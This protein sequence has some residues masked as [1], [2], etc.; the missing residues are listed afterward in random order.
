MISTNKGGLSE[1]GYN[2]VL[3]ARKKHAQARFKQPVEIIK[4]NYL[5][6]WV[7]FKKQLRFYNFINPMKYVAW[8]ITGPAAIVG[9]VL[10]SWGDVVNARRH[11]L[12]TR[13]AAVENLGYLVSLE[14]R[15]NPSYKKAVEAAVEQKGSK[16]KFK[17]YK[18]MYV[19][20]GGRIIFTAI[21]R[22]NAADVS[23]FFSKV[24]SPYLPS[25]T[26]G[27][28]IKSKHVLLTTAGNELV[29]YDPVSKEEKRF[30]PKEIIEK[31]MAPATGQPGLF[32]FSITTKKGVQ[33]FTLPEADAEKFY[34][35]VRT[36][37]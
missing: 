14:M 24:S 16:H 8:S 17:D 3:A 13:K 34:E 28:L 1:I 37:L 25:K 33:F 36:A 9:V 31:K 7:R 23:Y 22:K 27:T 11:S 10:K 35:T 26:D 21:E 12:A 6:L 32:A 15:R 5:E 2:A 29:V 19:D 18:W 20:S 4:K 30:K